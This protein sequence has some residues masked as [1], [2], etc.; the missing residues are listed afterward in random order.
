MRFTKLLAVVALVGMGNA[1]AVTLPNGD[2]CQI[3]HQSQIACSKQNSSKLFTIFVGKPNNQHPS[4]NFTG[5]STLSASPDDSMLYFEA[6]AW[7]T[8]GDVHFLNLKTGKVG[9]VSPG[10]LQ[11]VI[12]KGYYKGDL[13][14]QQHRYYAQGGSYNPLLI[15][16]PNGRQKGVL[17]NHGYRAHLTKTECESGGK[18]SD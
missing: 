6:A 12:Q 9:E 2:Y 8:S 7:A 5:M 10:E 17:A 15:Y 14:I 11:C 1:Y 16:S 3:F 13:V 4:Q 18:T